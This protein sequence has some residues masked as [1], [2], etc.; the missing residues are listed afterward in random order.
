M[1]SVTNLP[2]QVDLALY[3]GDDF[4]LEVIV[5]DPDGQPVDLTGYVAHS[6]IRPAPDDPVL[7]DMA[8][9]V[10]AN[11]VTVSMDAE[12]AATL[13]GIPAVWDVQVTSPGGVV[14]TLAAGKVAVTK[15]VTLVAP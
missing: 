3:R 5:T 14:T 7:A 13:D 2:L 8:A 6:Q 11:V 15:D 4:A 12:L 10:V 9:V 1:V